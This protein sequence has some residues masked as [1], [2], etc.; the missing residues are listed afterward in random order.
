M[1]RFD[2]RL[3]SVLVI[4]RRL[5]TEAEARY[6]L[7]IQSVR[8]VE[9][10][11]ADQRQRMEKFSEVITG[12][13]QKDLLMG[14]QQEVL[15]GSLRLARTVEKALEVSLK[16]ARL[17]EDRERVAYIEARRDFELLEK[18]KKRQRLQH[19]QAAV[20]EEQRELDDLFNARRLAGTDT[21]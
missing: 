9:Q 17:V 12:H 2:F 4:R 16:E 13:Q 21:R 20:A 19:F 8:A 6:A 7:A 18:L 1:K 5:L 11:I 14:N 3:Q 15:Y 10:R